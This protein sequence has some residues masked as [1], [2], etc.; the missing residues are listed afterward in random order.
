MNQPRFTAAEMNYGSTV[1]ST[2]MTG[3]QMNYPVTSW[4][5]RD[6]YSSC[7]PRIEK[8]IYS[9]VVVQYMTVKPSWDCSK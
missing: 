6:Q 4:I 5:N 9:T 8:L 1:P 3:A 7:Y 2:K